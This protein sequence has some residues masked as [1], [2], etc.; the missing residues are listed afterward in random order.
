MNSENVLH[1]EFYALSLSWNIFT[2][3]HLNFTIGA[4]IVVFLSEPLTEIY[5]F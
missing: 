1:I 2:P 5:V 4:Q 3:E